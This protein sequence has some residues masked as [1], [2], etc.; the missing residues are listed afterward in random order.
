MRWVDQH[1][2]AEHNLEQHTHYSPCDPK[3]QPL[4]GPRPA[5]LRQVASSEAK[6][7]MSLH[8]SSVHLQV[9]P[10]GKWK[11]YTRNIYV[12]RLREKNMVCRKV[13]TRCFVIWYTLNR[14]RRH[15]IY[16]YRKVATRCFVIWYTMNRDRQHII[17][18]YSNYLHL[19]E[20][21]NYSMVKEHYAKLSFLCGWR[22]SLTSRNPPHD[23]ILGQL[24]QVRRKVVWAVTMTYTGCGVV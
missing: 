12:G 14:D 1:D 13:A 8:R 24:H 18:L 17:C 9:H 22:N 3:P 19:W 20:S 4:L 15:I 23:H 6:S 10:T 5:T 21:I 11:R 7:R 2:R 16:L